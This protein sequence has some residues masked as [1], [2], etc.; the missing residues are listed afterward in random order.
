MVLAALALGAVACSDEEQAPHHETIAKLDELPLAIVAH[1]DT[2]YIASDAELVKVDDGTRSL[3]RIADGRYR[4]CPWDPWQKWDSLL[5]VAPRLTP[6][7]SAL[8]LSAYKCGAWAWPLNGGPTVPI[9]RAS[10][11]FREWKTDTNPVWDY[12]SVPATRDGEDWIACGRQQSNLGSVDSEVWVLEADGKPKERLAQLDG[13]RCEWVEAE[14]GAVYA[15]TSDLISRIDRTSKEVKTLVKKKGDSAFR[16]AGSTPTQ[17]VVLHDKRIDLVPKDGGPA[18]TIVEVEP[19]G[20][21]GYACFD[22]AVD[23]THVYWTNGLSL[24]RAPL[25]ELTKHEVLV[26]AGDQR[27]IFHQSSQLPTIALTSNAVWALMQQG[28]TVESRRPILARIPKPAQ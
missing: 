7:G 3:V 19:N 17:F 13:R 22:A 18:Q 4:E 2:V 8:L 12:S 23:T 10:R 14:P 15:A 21:C 1:G 5:G 16:V 26:P 9:A 6:D 25:A 27:R 20:H 24:V 28:E 11:D